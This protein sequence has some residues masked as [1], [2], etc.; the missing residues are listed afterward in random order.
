MNEENRPNYYAII[1]ADVR[2][3][4]N[5]NDKAKLLYGEISSLCNN[6]GFC[7]ASNS[8]F[9]NLYSV[10]VRT[11]IRLINELKNKGYINVKLEYN[12]D[13]K[14]VKRRLIYLV[15]KLSVPH[16]IDVSTPSDTDVTY[17]NTSINNKNN[18]Y[19]SLIDFY[20]DKNIF[21]K[22]LKL[23]DTRKRKIDARIKE[24]GYDNIIKAIDIASKSDFLIGKNERSWK[25]DFDWLISN[26]TNIVKILEGK[27]S[28]KK[29]KEEKGRAYGPILN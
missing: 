23:T 15:T 12:T 4:T 14:T 19:K 9:A 7:W 29:A 16:D 24:Q 3:D 27:Y 6:E 22:L 20:N 1:P 13:L 21:P 5:L 2:Y 11:I 18:I 10:S 17:N 8:Y 26:D 28:N 25:M